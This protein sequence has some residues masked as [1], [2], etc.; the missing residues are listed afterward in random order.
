[1]EQ[2]DRLVSERAE[3]GQW[4]TALID[5]ATVRAWIAEQG[6]GGSR[7]VG[8]IAVHRSNAWGV[9][10]RFHVT[11]QRQTTEVV[12][13]ANFLPLSFTGAAV[14]Q[15]LGRCS[16]G[17][18]PELIASVEEPGRRWE[19]FRVFEGAIVGTLG[20]LDPLL[21]V[22]RA[23]ARIQAAVSEH[24]RIGTTDGIPT[25]PVE[26]L[27]AMFDELLIVVKRRL[28]T[29]WSGDGQAFANANGLPID[30]LDVLA[31]ARPAVARWTGEAAAGGWPLTIH[32]VDLHSNNAV[33]LG[34][35]Q[36]LIFDW[37]EADIGFPFFAL[38]KLML[39][40]EKWWGTAGAAAVRSAYL[41]E[42][43]WGTRAER[44]R[45]FTVAQCLSPIRYA[46]AD[47]LFADVL[48]WDPAE[49]IAGWFALALQR[50]ETAGSL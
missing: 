50:W 22:A 43:P 46:F 24:R 36:T 31:E 1:M 3:A 6:P 8:P 21:D 29:S 25:T 19:L 13:K 45:A 20:E 7:V 15:L 48:G 34:N 41:D 12:F 30:V 28:L 10:A 33:R 23:F 26:R 40:A 17:D 44:E 42:I 37:E 32:H 5:P 27:P 2:W 49:Q 18:V 4:P 35:G 14:Y 47:L 11:N 38:D 9:T 16:P 39:D